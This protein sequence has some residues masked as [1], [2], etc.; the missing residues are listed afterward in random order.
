MGHTEGTDL[1][2]I[3]LLIGAILFSLGWAAFVTFTTIFFYMPDLEAKPKD[4]SDAHVE[5]AYRKTLRNVR[6]RWMLTYAWSAHLIL[7]VTYWAMWVEQGTILR[8]DNV[9]INYSR[10]IGEAAASFMLALNLAIFFWFE[11]HLFVNLGY[12]GLTAFSFVSLL[13]G[14]LESNNTQRIIWTVLSILS[15]VGALLWTGIAGQMRLVAVTKREGRR[16]RPVPLVVG[17]VVL[18]LVA[19]C[20]FGYWLFWLLG[21]NDQDLSGLKRR[22]QVELPWLLLDLV[23][24][25]VVPIITYLFY[26]PKE[27]HFVDSFKDGLESDLVVEGASRLR[28]GFKRMRGRKHDNSLQADLDDEEDVDV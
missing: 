8:S 9:R 25:V 16:G 5:R 19:V 10:W 22:W 21:R 7:A 2:G 24:Y 27:T 4:S 20:Y 1:L 15:F 3:L 18:I 26:H 14:T 28:Q 23:L 17:W 6:R 11:N 13:F 12:G